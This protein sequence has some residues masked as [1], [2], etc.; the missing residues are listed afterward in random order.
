MIEQRAFAD[1]CSLRNLR[2]RNVVLLLKELR[3]GI[4][5]LLFDIVVLGCSHGEPSFCFGEDR[6]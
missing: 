4:E 3:C 5:N 1:V 6:L 2:K